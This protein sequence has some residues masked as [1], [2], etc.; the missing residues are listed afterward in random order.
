MLGLPAPRPHYFM[1]PS[2]PFRWIP[3][4]EAPFPLAKDRHD[5]EIL[6]KK[7]SSWEDGSIFSSNTNDR[8]WC[9]E[10]VLFA[11]S[12]TQVAEHVHARHE[13]WEEVCRLSSRYWFWN[14][15]LHGIRV[16]T[17]NSTCQLWNKLV[18]GALNVSP[19]CV[20]VATCCCQ[21]MRGSNRFIMNK[22]WRFWLFIFLFS[23]LILSENY[24][25]N[26]IECTRGCP[27]PVS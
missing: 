22:R 6:N 18:G 17:P 10:S 11:I 8:A 25:I 20:S 26:M 7:V 2:T 14:S 15:C 21:S 4:S 13:G 23:I 24:S 16:N 5:R 3:P 9:S 1:K 12:K 27:R 19:T